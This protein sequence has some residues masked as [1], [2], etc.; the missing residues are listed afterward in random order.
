MAI[1]TTNTILKIG[2]DYRVF[3]AGTFTTISS[4]NGG[5]A[6]PFQSQFTGSITRVILSAIINTSVTNLDIGIMGPDA[7]GSLPSDTFIAVPNTFSASTNTTPTN[8]IINLNNSIS[9]IK[10]QVYY[11]TFKPNASFTGNLS[12]YQTHYG[13]QTS[14]YNGNY[15]VSTRSVSG[16]S[17][18]NGNSSVIYGNSTRWFSTDIPV[19]P[20]DISPITASANQEYGNA[21][22]LN[23]EHPAIRVKSIS[24]ANVISKISNPNMNFLC[25]IY[26]STGILLHTFA[27][28]D[29]DR[30]VA[31]FDGLGISY[32]FNRT[33]SDIWL[34]PATKYYIMFAFSGTFTNV[35]SIY[36]YPYDNTL[37]SAGGAYNSNYANRSSGGVM[38][39]ITT[40][41]MSFSLEVNGI[42]FDNSYSGIENYF[43]ASSMLNGG[44][45]G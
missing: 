20:N 12:I 6:L 8:Y 15:E 40:E 2:Y 28:E 35:P 37:S 24:F 19:V 7:A 32:F 5:L 9:V 22:T 3:T 44:F 38:T 36:T 34:E 1:I 18:G 43:Y 23:A 14:A 45:N 13:Y 10:G 29:S 39:E 25:K 16:W 26:D 41:L 11:L 27:T 31:S 33:E 30:I 17:R 42:R 21:F 4:S